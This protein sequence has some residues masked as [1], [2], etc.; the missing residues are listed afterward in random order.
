MFIKPDPALSLR[1]YHSRLNGTLQPSRTHLDLS[2]ASP[3]E[4]DNLSDI[5]NIYSYQVF[6]ETEKAGY[7]VRQWLASSLYDRIR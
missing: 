3:G 4:R 1:T 5:P 7:I 2:D 6:A